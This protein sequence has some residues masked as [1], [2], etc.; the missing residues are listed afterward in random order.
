MFVS[1]LLLFVR[2]FVCSLLSFT[3]FF[4]FFFFSFHFDFDFI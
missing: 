3:F 2:L 4:F 1:L